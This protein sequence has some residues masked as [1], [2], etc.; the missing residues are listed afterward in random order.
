MTNDK[1]PVSPM[2][3]PTVLALSSNF[4]SMVGWCAS[5]MALADARR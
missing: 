1:I 4:G 2:A 5:F 3:P